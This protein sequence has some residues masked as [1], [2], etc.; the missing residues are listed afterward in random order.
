MRERAAFWDD[1]H[2]ARQQSD[3]LATPFDGLL[4]MDKD[5]LEIGPGEGRQFDIVA[6]RAKSYS[7]ADIS[8]KVFDHS[9]YDM[10]KHK[11]LIKSYDDRFDVKFNLIHFWY[12]LHHVK[13]EELAAFVEFLYAHLVPGGFVLFNTPELLSERSDYAG[14]GIQTTWIDIDDVRIFFSRRFVILNA[15]NSL[16]KKSNGW[17]IKGGRK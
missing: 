2:L 11:L 10:C 15:D 5:V 17:V 16:Y 13:M 7:I 4:F 9:K 3:S 6:G 12:V 8:L 14:D 1:N